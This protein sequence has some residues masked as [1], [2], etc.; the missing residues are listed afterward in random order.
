MRRFH[1]W[2]IGDDKVVVD[3]NE[4]ELAAMI[5]DKLG[6]VDSMDI[7][8]EGVSEIYDALSGIEGLVDYLS[9]TMNKDIRRYFAAQTDKERDL[10]RGAFART[11]YI[12]ALVLDRKEKS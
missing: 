4:I 1:D 9:D 12:R 6:D 7:T 10:I 11:S 8:K 3:Y 2:E 5:A